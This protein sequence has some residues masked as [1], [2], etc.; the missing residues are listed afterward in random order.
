MRR[1]N[2]G[3]GNSLQTFCCAGTTLQYYC[4][5]LF[6]FIFRFTNII[7]CTESLLLWYDIDFYCGLAHSEYRTWLSDGGRQ[8]GAVAGRGPLL[9]VI[10]STLLIHRLR[11][12]SYIYLCSTHFK[13]QA[14]IILRFSVMLKT[15]CLIEKIF[16]Y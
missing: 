6:R 8:P 14:C 11:M 9:I 13:I 5:D 2:D 16:L 4:P 1:L 10:A 15:I 7:Y 12:Q 3:G